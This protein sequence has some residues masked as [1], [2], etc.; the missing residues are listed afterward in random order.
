VLACRDIASGEEA[1]DEIRKVAQNAVL[2]VEKLELCSFD[3][4]RQFVKNLGKYDRFRKVNSIKTFLFPGNTEVDV[5][6]NNAGVVFHPEGRTVD[7]HEFHLQT[8]Y[9][10]KLNSSRTIYK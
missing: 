6:I 5:L 8:N 1:R 4:I 3:S 10:G 7:G 2:V 9:L